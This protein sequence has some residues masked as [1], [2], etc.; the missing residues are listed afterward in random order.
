MWFGLRWQL[1]I[2]F[3]SA[4]MGKEAALGVLSSLFDATGG[5]SGVWGAIS[6]QKSAVNAGIAGTLLG[7]ISKP[8]ALAFIYA[9]FFNIPCLMAV[10]ST[11]QES[12]SLKWTLRIVVYYMTVALIMSF[13]AYHVGML[14]F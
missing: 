12:H 1:F 9:F 14:I 4:A 7:S 8:E 11:Y 3:L 13:L 6:A 10:A 5:T 2:A